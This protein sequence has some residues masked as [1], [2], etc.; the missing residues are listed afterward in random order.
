VTEA[1]ELPGPD[2]PVIVAADIRPL[3]HERDRN[4]MS[5]EFDLDSYEDVHTHAET[6]LRRLAEGRCPVTAHGLRKGSRSSDAGYRPGCSR[7]LGR[8]QTTPAMGAMPRDRFRAG[9]G[10]PES[11]DAPT[12]GS[13]LSTR[14]S[15]RPFVAAGEP[16]NTGMTLGTRCVL[17]IGRDHPTLH[18]TL[19]C[20]QGR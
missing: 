13:R 18:L 2:Q 11:Q 17:A 4:A 3:F 9:G 1:V 8:R 7:N 10:S 20:H 15:L 5:W 12:F 19:G 14:K 6:I 16:G